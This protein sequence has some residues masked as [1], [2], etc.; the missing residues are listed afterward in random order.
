MAKYECDICGK[1]FSSKRGLHI[2]QGQKHPEAEKKKPKKE[3]TVEKEI[4]EEK[5]EV[6]GV[7]KTWPA[8]ILLVVAA[9]A[10][11]I[12]LGLSAGKT[13][14]EQTQAPTRK[15]K[16]YE[17]MHNS[18]E[19]Q[20]LAE[21][22]V[23]GLRIPA[24]AEKPVFDKGM[25]IVNTTARSTKTNTTATIQVRIDDETMEPQKVYFLLPVPKNVD[26]VT[27]STQ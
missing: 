23:L 20:E 7:A 3:E 15:P 8:V 6:T 2:H 4:V 12:V 18:S 19:A 1:E 16:I 14:L 13:Q 22:V 27:N 17:P 26:A 9:M 5:E 21:K 10:I 24:E 11:G 25:W